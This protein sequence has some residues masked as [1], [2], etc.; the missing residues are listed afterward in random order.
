MTDT[1]TSAEAVGEI[2]AKFQGSHQRKVNRHAANPR[3]HRPDD[4]FRI[5]PDLLRVL[6]DERETLRQQ[7]ADARNAALDEAAARIGPK[8]YEP[9][10][11]PSNHGDTIELAA[12]HEANNCAAS[13]LALKT[14]KGGSEDG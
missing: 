5:I 4:R 2:A 12:W 3:Y 1:D 13:I 8:G 14:T 7:L 6:L 11:D 10:T 9:C